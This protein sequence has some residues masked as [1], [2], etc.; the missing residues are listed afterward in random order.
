MGEGTTSRTMSI[1]I[2]GSC[3]D[4]FLFLVVAAFFKEFKV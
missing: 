2:S 1:C 3:M 4:V